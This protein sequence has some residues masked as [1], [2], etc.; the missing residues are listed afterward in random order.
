MKKKRL[1]SEV[2]LNTKLVSSLAPNDALK[3]KLALATRK[4]NSKEKSGILANIIKSHIKK[5]H[6]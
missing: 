4:I 6:G 5:D 3:L 1:I 2:D